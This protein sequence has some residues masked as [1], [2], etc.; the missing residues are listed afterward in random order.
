MRVHTKLILVGVL[1]SLLVMMIMTIKAIQ[2]MHAQI[3]SVSSLA[4]EIVVKH[5]PDSELSQTIESQLTM[6]WQD[7]FDAQASIAI[8][9]LAFISILVSMVA[10]LL[11]KRILAGLDHLLAGVKEISNPNTPVSYRISEEGSKDLLNVCQG[12]NELLERVEGMIVGIS[13]MSGTV[14][15]TIGVLN[16]NT[17]ST[18]SNTSQLQASMESVATAMHELQAA[19][20]EIGGLVQKSSEE[21]S[22]INTQG[23][24]T[25][26]E[27]THIN[28]QVGNLKNTMRNSA[29]D[30]NELSTQ[31]EGVHS[32]LQTIQGIAEQTN[33]LA[34][35]AAI[36]AARAGEQGRGFAVVADEVRNLAGKTQQS[37]EEIQKMISALNEVA[38]RSIAAMEE[39]TG[40]TDSLVEQ[41]NI[42][43]SNIKDLFNRLDLVNDLNTQV[44]A[45]TEEQIQVIDE[46]SKNTTQTKDISSDTSSSAKST[47]EQARV[48]KDSSLQL[49]S[50]V[51]KFQ[52]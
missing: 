32:I 10:L 40:S 27:V 5:Y 24:K 46:I 51:K 43:N 23:R 17:E 25:A 16:H 11:V 42:A 9:V 34:L 49:E 37:T 21:V 22:D 1:P 36:E 7:V 4:A 6:G 38:K 8:P 20:N 35:N 45:A 41:F 31:V 33:L 2:D 12:L 28:H 26:E 52:L 3:E 19:S 14:N 13:K 50:M 48:L 18:E 15:H 47:A 39:S 44:A 29:N 30:V